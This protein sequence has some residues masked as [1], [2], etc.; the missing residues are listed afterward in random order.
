LNLIG[1]YSEFFRGATR[2]HRQNAFRSTHGFS[3]VE[4]LRADCCALRRRCSGP[5]A[6]L[7]RAISRD[8]V[9]ATDLSREP[10]RYRGLPVGSSLEALPHGVSRTGA[11]IDAGR[12]QR[13]ARLAHLRAVR[14]SVDRP[15]AKALCRRQL[16]FGVDQHGLLW[17]RPPSTCACRCFHGPISAP[18]K[19]R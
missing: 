4:H 6:A 15:G 19:R 10:A 2:E 16:G 7:R 13:V 18:P 9:C 17:T 14:P 1:R 11:A 5:N 8:G 3:A 12:C